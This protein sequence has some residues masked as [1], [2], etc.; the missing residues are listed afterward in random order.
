MSPDDLTYSDINPAMFANGKSLNLAEKTD[1]S[2][3]GVLMIANALND[4]APAMG[5]NTPHLPGDMLLCKLNLVKMK[6]PRRNPAYR[7]VKSCCCI[8][9]WRA[10]KSAPQDGTIYLATDGKEVTT[11]NQPDQ[12]RGR[13]QWRWDPFE[14][15]WMGQS[16]DFAATHWQP[17]PKPPR[18]KRTA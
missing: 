4:M 5:I 7:P 8:M 16:N 10:I 18:T 11:L 6:K 3:A 1:H 9:K 17:L 2:F 14:S 15:A 13:G 12:G